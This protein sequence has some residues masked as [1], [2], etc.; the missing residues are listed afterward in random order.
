MRQSVLRRD[1]IEDVNMCGLTVATQRDCIRDVARFAT[2]VG[3]L[4]I[5]VRRGIRRF[6]SITDF[7]GRLSNQ[8]IDPSARSIESRNWMVPTICSHI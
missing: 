3:H 8:P 7:C 4:P 5:S 2:F 6:Q 1:S